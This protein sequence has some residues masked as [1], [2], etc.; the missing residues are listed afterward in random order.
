LKL[1][2]STSYV[3]TYEGDN[4]ALRGFFDAIEIFMS[5][6]FAVTA[7]LA[8]ILNLALPEE[9]EDNDAIDPEETETVSSHDSGAAGKT[10]PSEPVD[11]KQH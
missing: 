7:L 3:F 2:C 10:M 1:T 4:H 8:M 5:T 6:G 9:L 11:E